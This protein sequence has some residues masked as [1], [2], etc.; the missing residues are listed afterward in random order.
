MDLRYIKLNLRSTDHRSNMWPLL[1]L[2]PSRLQTRPVGESCTSAALKSTKGKGRK[3]TS[4]L[5]DAVGENGR[6]KEREREGRRMRRRET[7]EGENCRRKRLDRKIYKH[8]HFI[9][10]IAIRLLLLLSLTSS[11]TIP[12]IQIHFT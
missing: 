7:G 1:I 5:N 2:T 9:V 8:F 3:M 11:T 4:I 10:A 6:G 12:D